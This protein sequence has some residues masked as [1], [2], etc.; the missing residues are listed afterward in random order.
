MESHLCSYD[1]ITVRSVFFN[2]I[3]TCHF[4]H[5]F[6]CFC[7]GVLIEDLVHSDRFTDFFSKQCLWNGIWI[8]KG[9]H[10]VFYLI[11]DSS[12]NFRVTVSCTVYCNTSIKIKIWCSVF[13]VYIHAVCCLSKK[14]KTFISLDHVLVYFVFDVL[15]S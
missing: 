2:T 7:T 3:F 15:K 14:I 10:D 9:M 5:C 12:Y 8:V 6:V 13:I 4:D 11:F 1:M